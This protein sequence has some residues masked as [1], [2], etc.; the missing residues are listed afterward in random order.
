MGQHTSK[1]GDDAKERAIREKIEALRRELSKPFEPTGRKG[2]QKQLDAD[3]KRKAQAER[4]IAELE[5]QLNG[6]KVAPPKKKA[7]PA[8]KK[9]APTWRRAGEGWYIGPAGHEIREGYDGGFD[10]VQITG[11]TERTVQHFEKLA[12]A[13]KYIPG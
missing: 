12:D 10:V 3:T 2:W 9:P 5:R 8:E 6:G 11:R 7:A 13:K 1:S 4:K